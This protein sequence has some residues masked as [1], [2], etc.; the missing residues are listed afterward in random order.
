MPTPELPMAI[1][2]SARKSFELKL[3]ELV[4]I[5]MKF[6]GSSLANADR[7]H[8]VS[9]II[10]MH[11]DQHPI[12]VLSA[13]G[14]TTDD[15]IAAGKA[16]ASGVVDFSKIEARHIAILQELHLTNSGVEEL[17]DECLKLLEGIAIVKELTP[18]TLDQLLSFGER[19]STRIF[20]AYLCQ[21]SLPAVAMDG[22]TAGLV[23]TSDFNS[24]EL[25]PHTYDNIANSFQS[26]TGIP[27]VTGF[28][29]KDLNGAITTLG[30]G[31]SDLT[32]AVIGA[33][34][35]VTEIQVWKDVHGILSTDPRVVEKAIPV[36][37]ISF[38][39]ASELAYF[40]AKVLHPM[41]ILPAMKKGIPVRVKNSYDPTHAGTLIL[42]DVAH[43]NGLVTA[44]THKP[45]QAMVHICSTR[46]LGQ[47][48][49][50]AKVFQIFDTLKI[51]VDV[52]ATSEVS[53]SLTLESQ[54]ALKELEEQLSAFATVRIQLCKTIVSL[55]GSN[56]YS[57]NILE[58][59]L[60]VL[61]QD[62]IAVHMISHGASTV[63]T[64]LVINDEDAHRSIHLLHEHF[65]SGEHSV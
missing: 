25:L 57:S 13:I 29:A 20:A 41:S 39:E 27:V 64:S 11:L 42:S 21:R 45:S 16:A 47:Y 3:K 30:R 4:M 8:R 32:A 62:G 18:R 43:H 1:F 56:Q 49:F 2:A 51:S 23:T 38:E 5:I 26:Y 55:I 52:I 54:E 60:K 50:L 37:S 34:L 7:I 58:R 9:R 53:I 12:V 28:I 31:G 17:L 19:L 44:I 65:F 15:L 10:E 14:K 22:W 24:A 59:S 46:M 33:A 6:G 48:G 63:N 36:A 35:S 61:S 40:G